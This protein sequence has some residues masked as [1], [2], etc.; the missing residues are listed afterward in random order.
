VLHG[1]LKE[2]EVHDGVELVVGVQAFSETL[3]HELAVGEDI[4]KLVVKTTDEV[5]EDEDLWSG[6]EVLLEVNLSES[7]ASDVSS[8]LAIL[9]QMSVRDEPIS[10]DA[11][12]LVNPQLYE[13]VGLTDGLGLRIEETLE[14]VGQVADIELVVEVLSGLAEGTSHLRVEVQGRLDDE[15]YLLM[16]R[17]LELAKMLT[18]VGAVDL[19]E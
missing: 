17:G 1:I 4:V 14:H 19:R 16:D 15:L 10:I 12:S 13:L 7:L 9:C 2:Y 5:G 11:L 3:S 18:K 6:A 8:N